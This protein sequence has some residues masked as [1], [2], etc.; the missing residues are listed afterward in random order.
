MNVFVTGH[1]G[2]IG[3]HLIPLLKEA[4]H[5]VTGCDLNL[6][7][8]CEWETLT[9]PDREL[10]KDIRR[11]TPRDL[12][13]YDCVMHLAAISN[14]PMGDL[15]PEITYSINRDGS[16]HLAKI[17]KQAGI[18]RFLFSSSC[19]AYG[20]GENLELDETA[21]LNP[22]SVYA[23]SKIDTE[24]AVSAMADTNFSP[25]FLRNATAY[26]HSPMLRIDLVANNFLACAYTTGKIRI[27]SD[28]SPWRP[29]IHCKDIARTFV[30]FMTAPREA[31][32]NRSVNVGANGGNYQ[33]KDVADRVKW[34]VPMAEIEFTGEVGEDPRD[35][36]VK[37]DLLFSMLPDFRLEYELDNGME[38]LY[39]R[40]VLNGFNRTDFEGDRFV[41]LRTLTNKY[42]FGAVVT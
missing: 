1:K 22:V 36:R 6:F 18:P 41:R 39:T 17:A 21:Q 24:K 34:L 14:D 9:Q 33:V 15:N 35:Y 7:E 13:G 37:F 5:H 4:G 40:F 25:V 3:A 12:E 38:E 42:N 16:I 31:V 11:L 32:H 29:L 23:K 19:S 10:C 28:G 8:G 27:M 26:G 20:R 2:F 30:A